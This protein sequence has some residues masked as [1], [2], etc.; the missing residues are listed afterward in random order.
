MS[1][2]MPCGIMEMTN[3]IF[4]LDESCKPENPQL[5]FSKKITLNN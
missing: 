4:G 2:K 3:L 1:G 5:Y